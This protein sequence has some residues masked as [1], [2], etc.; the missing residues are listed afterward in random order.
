MMLREVTVMAVK[1]KTTKRTVTVKPSQGKKTSGSPEKSE[2]ILL[3][4]QLNRDEI[5]WLVTQAKTIVYNHKIDDVN[6][7]AKDLVESKKRTTVPIKKTKASSNHDFVDIIQAG[8]PKNYNIVVGNA[9]LFIN[10]NELKSMVKITQAADDAG[11]GAG[12]LFRWCRRERNDMLIDSGISNPTDLRL[13]EIYKII[14]DR[15]T[16]S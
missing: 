3:L 15:Y 16:V 7:A 2:L 10:I 4:D 11:D 1:K 9:R 12:R 8:G 13:Q 5:N 6:A 14:K